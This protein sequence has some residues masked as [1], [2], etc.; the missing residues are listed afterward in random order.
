MHIAHSPLARLY[1]Y[2]GRLCIPIAIDFLCYVHKGELFSLYTYKS[3][4][5]TTSL[6][7]LNCCSKL[8][9]QFLTFCRTTTATAQ[10]PPR[11][12]HSGWNI[13]H[14]SLF[15]ALFCSGT[16]CAWRTEEK[17]ITEDL[18]F[19]KLCA[20][21]LNDHWKQKDQE[22]NDFFFSWAIVRVRTKV[23]V[24]P[25]TEEGEDLSLNQVQVP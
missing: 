12:C 19:S 15:L 11:F 10:R 6:L 21:K 14:H 23:P 4:I 25:Y 16:Y 18:L 22:R 9:L 1:T 7:G 8:F 17:I 13:R 24:G 20:L 3:S 2:P 5:G